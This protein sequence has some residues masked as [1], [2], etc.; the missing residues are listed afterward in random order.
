LKKAKATKKNYNHCKEDDESNNDED[1]DKDDDDDDENN[2]DDDNDE[3][4]EQIQN[5]VSL[6]KESSKSKVIK[7]KYIFK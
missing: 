2:G 6:N 4:D 1:D 3:N 7:L 5:E